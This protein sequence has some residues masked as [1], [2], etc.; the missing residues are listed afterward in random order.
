MTFEEFSTKTSRTMADLHDTEKNINHTLFG[1]VTELGEITDL[2]KK[3]MAYGK[4]FSQ[5]QLMDETGD[6]LFY[7]SEFIRFNKMDISVILQKNCDKL[8]IRFP[9][10][11]DSERAISP[12]KDTEMEIFIKE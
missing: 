11:F 7:L 4:L 12:D 3:K 5:E 6:L 1:M 10:K 9:E 8:K 2:F